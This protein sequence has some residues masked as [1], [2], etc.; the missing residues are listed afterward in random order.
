[1]ICFEIKTEI[2][3][4]HA[5]FNGESFRAYRTLIF[6]LKLE[7][8]IVMQLGIICTQTVNFSLQALSHIRITHVYTHWL[9]QGMVQ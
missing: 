1:M 5:A 7:I 3:I 8:F 9:L 2:F 6:Y 4:I